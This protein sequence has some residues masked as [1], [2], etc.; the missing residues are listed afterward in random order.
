MILQVQLGPRVD[1]IAIL[2][3]DSSGTT[4]QSEVAVAH[5]PT[6]PPAF[7]MYGLSKSRY[8]GVKLPFDLGPLGAPG[9]TLYVSPDLM[10]PV[11]L[12]RASF[13]FYLIGQTSLPVPNVQSLVGVVLY[14]QG[15]AA[16][17]ASNQ[18]GFVSSAAVEMRIGKYVPP[19][20]RSLYAI[21]SSAAAGKFG[22]G[23]GYDVGGPI[24]Q[25]SGT[26]N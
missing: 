18:L 8:G 13:G 25:L 2:I 6:L 17:P 9:N 5:M 21:D 15:V 11:V 1:E 24:L 26:F 10:L 22:Y 4:I 19:V 7:V 3:K 12:R 23:S 16:H 20:T 14:G